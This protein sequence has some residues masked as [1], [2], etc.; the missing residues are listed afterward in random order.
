MKTPLTAGLRKKLIKEFF[1]RKS[2]KYYK[3]TERLILEFFKRAPA[4]RY[5]ISLVTVILFS[6][7]FLSEK[8]LA[9]PPV[10]TSGTGMPIVDGTNTG[11][12]YGNGV[13]V[14]VLS[15]GLIYLSADGEVWSKVNDPGITA[16][17]FYGIAFGAGKFVVIGNEG[18]VLTSSNGLNWTSRTSGTGNTLCDVQFLQSSFYAVGVNATLITSG[19]GI[20]WNTITIGAGATTEEFICIAYGNG[21]FAIGARLLGDGIYI[22]SSPTG[23]SN[24][25]AFQDVAPGYITKLQYLKDKFFI[26]TVSADVI[27]STD[28]D[29]WSN[30]TASMTL[31]LPDAT[32]QTIGA[33][34]L[35]L[36]GMYDGIKVYLFGYSGYFGNYGSIF[37]SADGVSFTLE[38]RTSYITCLG[39]AWINN[40]YFQFG[41]EGILSSSNGLNYKYTGGSY[42]GAASS[43]TSYVGI[44]FAGQGGA[45]FSSTD[46]SA[47]TDRTPEYQKELRAIVYTGTKYVATGY[48]TIIESVDNGISW[49]EIAT[50]PEVFNTLAIGYNL[51]VSGVYDPGTF[52]G[53]IVYSSNGISWTI[54]NTNNNYYYKTKIVNGNFFA[55]GFSN[56]TYEGVILHSTDGMAWTDITPNLPFVVSYFNDVVYDGIKYHFIGMES[57]FFSISTSTLA[58]PNSYLN[59]GIVDSPPAGVLPGGTFGEGAFAYSGGRFVGAVNDIFTNE[60]Y[61]IYSTSGVNWN[62]VAV[63]EYT[64]VFGI[65]AEGNRFRLMGTND[66]K[67]IAEF[68]G[69]ALPVRL[70]HFSGSLVNSQSILKWQTASEMHSRQFTVQH[71]TDAANWRDVGTVMAAGQSQ[72][73]N[74]YQFI[75]YPAS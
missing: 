43:G 10:I 42:Y 73:V 35:V 58:N 62:V 2:E 23:S 4:F 15:A 49:T 45:V 20:T 68:T 48:Q 24:T 25:W 69:I 13:Y 71:S 31:T 50:P 7:F 40:K 16:G 17:T 11:I 66:G 64:A 8:T 63:N 60:T 67:I 22:Y 9:Q 28:A 72:V 41:N 53:S 55:L 51:L 39:S 32:N 47:W 57:V 56:G 75:H 74:N 29:V 19:D 18:L 65:V 46:F 52:V 61:I 54:A 21:V 1:T 30:S 59:K 14:S 38:P 44:G 70:S 27:T 26:F 5:I 34:N 12:A 6:L 3:K 37:S 33:P 36:N